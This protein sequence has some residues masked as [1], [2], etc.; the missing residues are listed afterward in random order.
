MANNMTIAGW[1][2]AQLLC[3]QSFADQTPVGCQLPCRQQVLVLISVQAVPATA[4]SQ[5]VQCRSDLHAQ[6]QVCGQQQQSTALA[7]A[8]V[9]AAAV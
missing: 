6:Q 7:V 9:A 8:V 1:P 4:H 3:I 5:M 2:N